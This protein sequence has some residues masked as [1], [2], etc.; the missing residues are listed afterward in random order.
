MTEFKVKI[1]G[2]IDEAQTQKIID[3]GITR[4]WEPVSISISLS[5]NVGYT[6]ILFRRTP[7]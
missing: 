5:E 3:E 6:A 1:I 4:G 7:P 2:A